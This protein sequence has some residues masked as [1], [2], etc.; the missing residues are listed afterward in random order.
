MRR[1]I[2]A[3]LGLV[4]V[5][6]TLLTAGVSGG[7]LSFPHAKHI[8]AGAECSTCHAAAESKNLKT[9][10]LPKLDACVQCHDQA[11]LAKMGFTQAPTRQT[12]FRKFS[13]KDHL[14]QN[15]TCETCHGALTHP[16]WAA[17]GKGVLGHPLCMTCHDGIKAS[18]DCKSCHT[19]LRE[20]RLH[21]M[22]RDPSIMKPM[23]HHPGFLQ[24]HQFTARMDGSKCRDCHRQEDFCSSCHEGDNTVFLTHE[25]NWLF[26]HPL[27]AR[28]N[29]NDCAA[30]HEIG[31]FCTDCHAAQGVRPGDHAAAGWVEVVHPQE[32]R[33]DITVCASCHDSE[34]S[35]VCARC[36]RDTG[37]QGDQPT[38]NI[39]P[40]GFKESAGHGYWHEDPNASCFQC[41]NGGPRVAGVGFCGYCHGSK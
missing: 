13:H 35:F 30:C 32:A 34:N 5:A 33:K 23:D 22:E 6:S 40:P 38:L 16:D 21:G 17:Q 26:T 9:S 10:L 20:G 24:D 2:P 8:E 7:T 36:H 37:G 25:R 28:K 1:K 41:H 3:A 31:T 27:A 14:A 18:N 4:L 15:L 11:E 29:L 12:G 19:S 39:H